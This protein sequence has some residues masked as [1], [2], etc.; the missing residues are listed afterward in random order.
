M[1][2]IS[3]GF[4]LIELMIVVAIIGLLAS[5]ALPTY[6]RY[7]VRV[8]ESACL[9]EMKQYASFA[10]VLL[11]D[12]TSPAPDPAPRSACTLADNATA[13]GTDITG[14][15]RGPGVRLTRCNMTTGTCTLI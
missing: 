1:R 12:P 7:R 11:Q 14:T 13:L 6:T 9:A 4:T 10:L 3:R 8:A 2:R 5:I 15:P